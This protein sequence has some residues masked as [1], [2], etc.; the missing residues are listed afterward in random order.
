MAVTILVCGP[1]LVPV[2]DPVTT[3]TSLTAT[4][5]WND[6]GSGSFTAPINPQLINAVTTPGNRI[7]LM[8]DGNIFCSGPIEEPDDDWDADK[9]GLGAAGTCTV[10]WATNEVLLARH[11]TYPDPT[12]DATAQ[13]TAVAWTATATNAEQVM[14]N[15]VNLNAGPGAL[16]YRQEQRLQLG[17]AAGVGTAINESTR[18]ETLTDVLRRD[19]QAGGGLGFRVREDMAA[20][21]LWFEVYKPRDLSASIRFSRQLNNLRALKVTRTAPTCTAAIVGGDGTGTDR[22]IVERTNPSGAGWGRWEKFVNQAGTGGSDLTQQQQAGDKALTDGGEI[23]KVAATAVDGPTQTFGRD[24]WLGDLVSIQTTSGLQ[25]VDL[26]SSATLTAPDPNTR[27]V[28]QPVIGLDTGHGDD[29]TLQTLRE[30]ERRIAR[31]ERS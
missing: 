10:T 8:R 20:N 25:L 18:F 11:I 17:V 24:F 13:T 29:P 27:E 2:A 6:T 31:L 16:S 15:L 23:V 21:T 26:V 12:L 30:M 14:R 9:D 4:V 1:N 7:A 19:A 28:V 5:K 22:Q 3:W